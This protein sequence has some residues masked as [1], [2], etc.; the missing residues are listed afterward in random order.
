MNCNSGQR[1]EMHQGLARDE[2]LRIE[3]Y[4]IQNEQALRA[5]YERTGRAKTKLSEF[6]FAEKP[7]VPFYTDFEIETAEMLLASLDKN[8]MRPANQPQ[9]RGHRVRE[10]R[11]TPRLEL[12]APHTTYG[13]DGPLASGVVPTELSTRY[14]L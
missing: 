14:P 5:V 4:E 9:R 13:G 1:R 6:G 8:S 11:R 2:A 12:S 3:F 10:S 7:A